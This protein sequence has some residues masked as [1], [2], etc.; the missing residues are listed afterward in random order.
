MTAPVRSVTAIVLAGRR[1]GQVDPLAAA[2]GLADKCLVPVAGKP[3]I[4]HVLGALAAAPEISRIIVSTNDPGGLQVVDE[5]RSM[6]ASGDLQV[7][8]A[9]NNLVD[10]LLEAV[11]GARYPVL[12]TTA[13]NALL[14]A[15]AITEFV[16]GAMET[17]VAVAFTRRHSVLAAHPDGQ[18][19][20]YKFSDD[21]YSN[22]NTYWIGSGK[23]LDIAE[24]FRSG[25]QFAKHP[26][27]IVEAFGLIN[28]LRFHYGIGSLDAAFK[29]FSRRF[30]FRIKAVILSDGAVAIDVDNERTRAVAET[31]LMARC[32]VATPQAHDRVDNIVPIAAGR[33]IRAAGS[34][35]DML[36]A[37]DP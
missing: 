22:C 30:G 3:M 26:L 12:V 20:F 29:R 11:A 15:E 27:R 5:V 16:S 25:G 1:D 32:Q 21:S 18:R 8:A 13:D 10:S 31:I 35:V 9:Q 14:T 6:V 36:I 4:A 24:V 28:L 37:P 17:D 7:S 23:A 33:E 2:A 19:R 34:S